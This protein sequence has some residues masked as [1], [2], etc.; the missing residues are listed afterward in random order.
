MKRASRLVLAATG[1]ALG[2]CAGGEALSAGAPRVKGA[3]PQLIAAEARRQNVPASLALRVAWVESRHR[4]N[5]VGPR[6]R[7]GRGQGPLQIM[8]RS[9][10]GLGHRGGPLNNCGAGLHYGM[11]HLAMCYRLAGGNHALAARCHVA[12]PG[13]LRNRSRYVNGYVRSVMR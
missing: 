1:L 4:C 7:I 12:G 11:K 8:P 3:A 5:A 13:G 9:A 10:A 6:T 2:G